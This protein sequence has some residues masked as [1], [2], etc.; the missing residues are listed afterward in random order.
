MNLPH[1]EISFKLDEDKTFRFQILC[2]RGSAVHS[3]RYAC[4]GHRVDFYA[5]RA[6]YDAPRTAQG[7][8]ERNRDSIIRVTRMAVDACH[9]DEQLFNFIEG[10]L[11]ETK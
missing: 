2:T 6:D 5:Y 7:A 11:S 9:L 1:I 10:I 3:I 4:T 8:C